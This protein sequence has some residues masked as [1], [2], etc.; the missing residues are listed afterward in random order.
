MNTAPQ[1]LSLMEFYILAKTYEAG[2]AELDELWEVAV[3]MY[4]NDEIANFNAAN[5]AI[6]KG[7]F[8]R[9]QRYLDKAGDSP[10]VEY[11]RGCIEVLKG[12]YE[13]SLPYF[14]RA[15]EQGLEAA[16]PVI[17]AVSNHWT[18]KRNKR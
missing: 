9:A 3:R 18:V 13:A 11:S 14:K 17:E 6:D 8:E 5:S 7:D 1:K 12:Q 15:Y 16:A 10:E 2:S 4:P